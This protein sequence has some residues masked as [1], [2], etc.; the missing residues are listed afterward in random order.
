[1]AQLL[2][3]LAVLLLLHTY[4]IYP[5][6]LMAFEGV[7]QVLAELR[8]IRTWKMP[9]RRSFDQL[10][11]VSMVV[12]AYNEA[13]CIGKKVSNSLALDYPPDRFQL[14]IGSDG[15]T[16]GTDKIVQRFEDS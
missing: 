3:W 8:V 13:E 7:A 2:F 5:L 6:L 16:D 11:M 4:V 9:L 14:L 10:P 15:S 1:M 12:S